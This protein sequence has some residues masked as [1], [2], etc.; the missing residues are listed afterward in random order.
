MMDTSPW[1]RALL[2]AIAVLPMPACDRGDPFTSASPTAMRLV[3]N[4]TAS[5][6]PTVV[7]FFGLASSP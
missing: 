2:L 7:E 4:A 1:L 5:G 6:L 3:Q